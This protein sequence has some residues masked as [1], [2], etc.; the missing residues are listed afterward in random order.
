MSE[1]DQLTPRKRRVR[2]PQQIWLRNAVFQ[3]HLWSGIS[4]G[5]Y[6]FFISV[7][8]SVL[9]YR[10]EL[11]VAATPRPIISKSAEPRLSDDQLAAAAR[12]AFS[13]YEVVRVV[14]AANP[15]QAVDVWLE[16]GDETKRRLFDPR[17]G[18]DLGNSVAAGI[19]LVSTL[20]RL[21]DNL[22]GGPTGRKVNGIGALALLVVAITGLGIWW[23]GIDM[24][25]RNLTLHRGISW[26][27]LA[28]DLHSSVGFWSLGFVLVFGASGLYLCIPE[29]FHALADRLE[30]M[31]DANAGRRSVDSALSWLAYLHFGR[32]NGI[33]IP[34]SG[35][36]VC[37]QITKAIWTV[38][39]LAPAV[40]SVTG[41]VMWWNR[42]LRPRLGWASSNPTAC[43]WPGS[44]ST[45]PRPC[46]TDAAD[47]NT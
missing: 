32:I 13:G 33:G 8:G 17:S 26:Q 43:R 18:T 31:T 40:M 22:L 45:Q 36:G 35:P 2:Q 16:R 14:R 11:Y 4:F 25:R 27:H 1:S 28:S 12:R 24:W 47:C 44:G 23:P 6:I 3:I 10:N 7:T 37:D 42:V 9:V 15:D 38:F 39:G 46:R 21:H 5:L 20:I 30:P 29:T 34:C 41:T 19:R